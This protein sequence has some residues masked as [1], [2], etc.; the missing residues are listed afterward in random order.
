VFSPK[1]LLRHKLAV[2]TLGE[3]GERTKFHRIIPECDAMVTDK[4]V[5]RLVLCTGKVYYDLLAARRE[6]GIDDVAIVRIEQLY[7]WPRQGLTQ[8]ISRYAN[9]EVVWCQEEPANM[10]AWAYVFPKLINIQEKL[11]RDQVLPAYVGRKE[12]AS[13][14]TGLFSKHQQEQ[15][16]IVETALS[17]DSLA[18]GRK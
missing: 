3:M 16:F 13:P 7:P 6:A 14:A 4:K 15:A 10:G 9:A 11:G 12:A 17:E 5:R 1:S 18:P 2:S 8:Q